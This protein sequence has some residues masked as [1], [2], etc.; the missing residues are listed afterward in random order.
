MLG[1]RRF[2]FVVLGGFFGIL[3]LLGVFVLLM[4]PYGNLPNLLFRHHAITDSNQRYQYPS[5]VRSGRFDSLVIGTSDARLL[6]PDA[7]D[8]I[9]GG[10]FANLA[11]SAGLAWEQYQIAK[12]FIRAVPHPRTLLVA[13]DH[14][15]CDA[16][17][18]TTRITFRGFPKWMYDDNPWNDY[19]YMLNGKTVEISFRRLGV[20]LGIY[21]PRFKAGYEVFTPPESA[22]DP[23]KVHRKLWAQRHGRPL[24]PVV[25]PYTP[26]AA[27]RAAWKFPALDWLDDLLAKFPG[28]KVLAFM[29]AHIVAQPIP[30]SF[31]AAREQECKA[32]I[33]EI[34]Q[35]H[36]AS[37][38]IDFRIRSA[39]TSNDDNYWDPLHYRLPI[40]DRVV[41]D[42][43][44]ALDGKGDPNGDWRLLEEPTVAAIS[45]SH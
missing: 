45:S 36:G 16:E 39:I 18:G 9:F 32:R 24:D 27:Q 30:G 29:P 37:P 5:L 6:K 8:K 42:I 23:V 7:L 38:V 15:W 3:S 2:L 12:L 31:S 20:A 17:A 4:N 10:H 26:T 13:L 25:P 34:A 40:A 28:R 11:M 33:A 44:Q 14:V 19:L 41:S 43:A 1:W 35:R 22:Y 21:A